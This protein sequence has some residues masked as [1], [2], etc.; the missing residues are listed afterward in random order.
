MKLK[1]LLIVLLVVSYASADNQRAATKSMKLLETK[2]S[3][4][5]LGDV[6]PEG[7]LRSQLIIQSKGLTGHLDEFVLTDSKWKGGDGFKLQGPP[8]RYISNYLEGL[9]PLAYILGDQKLKEKSQEYIEWILKNAKSDGWF[10]PPREDKNG[11]G[12]TNNTEYLCGMLKMLMGYYEA[13]G[14]ARVIP[15][16][17]NYFLY[18]DQQV[19]TWP[20]GA[21]WGIRAMEHA[22]VGYWLYQHTEDPAFLKSVEK[23]HR[24]SFDWSKFFTNFPWDTETLKAGKIPQKW[25][26]TGKTAHGVAL[27]WAIKFPGL[28][29]LLSHK[30]EDKDAAFNAIEMLDRHHGQAGGR[31]SCDE[32]LNGRRPTSG[33]ELCAVAEYMYS[34]EKLLEIF[35]DVELADR[36][37]LLAFNSLPGTMT[38]DCWAHQYDQQ[39]NQVLVSVAKRE[40]SS[41]GNTANIYGLRPQYP[42]CMGNMHHAWPRLVE[43]MW[44]ST[45]DNGLAALVFG[46]CKVSTKAADGSKISIIE[47]TDYPFDGT[48]RFR[49]DLPKELSFPFHIRI[50]A[51]ADK[52]LVHYRDKTLT[53]QPGTVLKI[54]AKWKS[55]DVVELKLPM[56]VRSESRYNNAI[57]LLRGPLYFSL[58][59]KKKYELLKSYD[60]KGAADWAIKPKTPWNYALWIDRK[61][62]DE[63]VVVV[64]KNIG[65][66]PYADIGDHVFD[67]SSGKFKTYEQDP[68]VLLK[69]RGKRLPEWVMEN[70]S[71]GEIPLGPVTS[72]EPV[73][74]LTLVP[75]GCARLRIT[76]FPCLTDI[77][78]SPIR[79]PN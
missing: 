27:A 41:N 78:K 69:V 4:L 20:P 71:C 30:Q 37:E 74:E 73:E 72:N 34:L 39:A 10:G 11:E 21:W 6:Q 14:D 57:S 47:E 33:T 51:W 38:P 31:F 16:A 58:R 26:A 22:V 53:P 2:Y 35:G 49:F 68:P 7:W 13:T 43:H 52:A 9:V 32:H 36:L 19:D 28:W 23:I 66:F 62:L 25:G 55:G 60:Y 75:Y 76:E 45:P 48:V 3:K 63:D 77:F 61:C 15:L 46:P 40:W 56:K 42:C 79:R 44:M 18:L 24:N 67:E 8:N 12:D 17:R 29:Y 5:P 65:A 64:R 59:I 70:N 50:P 1:L 54:D